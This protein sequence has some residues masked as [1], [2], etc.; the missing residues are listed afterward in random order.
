MKVNKTLI[1]ALIVALLLVG[2]YIGRAN[3]NVQRRIRLFNFPAERV[4]AVSMSNAQDSLFIQKN[5]ETGNWYAVYPL[6]IKID[7]DRI[8]RFFDTVMNVQRFNRILTENSADY[9]FYRVTLETATRVMMLD[10]DDNVLDDYFFGLADMLTYGAARRASERVVYELC[11]DLM[12]EVLPG[13]HH[14]RSQDI[15]S[16]NRAEVDSIN[17]KFGANEYSLINENNRWFYRDKSEKFLFTGAHRT[18]ARAMTQLENM[19]TMLFF[20]NQW[21]EYRGYF[22]SPSLELNIYSRNGHVDNL[23][24]ARTSDNS[25]VIMRNNDTELLYSGTASMIFRFTQSID[26]FKEVFVYSL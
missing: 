16:F 23:V 10:K 11:Q 20:D 6:H 3:F 8:N 21:D 24:F 4:F 12:S 22:L 9:R 15:I 2:I 5:I 7:P 26:E 13:L 25:V 19:S 18:F 1:L 14:W 17:V